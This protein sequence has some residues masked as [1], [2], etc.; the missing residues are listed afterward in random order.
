MGGRLVRLVDQ[1]IGE[2]WCVL[3]ARH[4]RRVEAAVDV[5]ERLTFLGQ[6]LRVGVGQSLR[7]GQPLPDLAVA[8]EPGE[9]L[10]RRD[11]REV[12]RPAL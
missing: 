11:E 8:I 4:L 9:V 2:Q 12:H 5:D 3:R 10:R 7:V 6:P 1:V